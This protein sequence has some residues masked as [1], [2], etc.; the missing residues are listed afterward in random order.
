MVKTVPLF[1]YKHGSSLVHRLDARIKLLLIFAGGY[2]VFS[3]PP[4]PCVLCMAAV[5]IVSLSAGFTPA[6]QLVQLKPA[7]YY[8]CLLYSI[9]LIT[10]VLA[11]IPFPSL[12]RPQRSDIDLTLRLALAVQFTGLLYRT[13][14][15]LELRTA[16]EQTE[17]A[18]RKLFRIRD[19]NSTMSFHFSEA[20]SL[21]LVFIPQVFDVW[22]EI[23]RTW[24]ARNGRGG[25]RSLP[26]LF[27]VFISV[28]MKRSYLTALALRSRS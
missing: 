23:Y 13:T 7:A 17:D 25:L 10:A 12:L 24:R 9:S 26:V 20:L 11:R 1:S 21:L 27:P 22:Q 15:S 2:A 5:C 16:L 18:V 8:A 3:L 28:C 6:E 4:V 14:S 19:Q